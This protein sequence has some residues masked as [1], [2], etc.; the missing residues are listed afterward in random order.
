MLDRPEDAVEADLRRLAAREIVRRGDLGLRSY[1]FSHSLIRDLAYDLLV[2]SECVRRHGRI[3]DVLEAQQSTDYA[4]VGFHHDRAGHPEPAARAKLR[5][6]RICRTTG[7]Y[8]EGAALTARAIELIGDDLPDV[9]LRLEANELN[10]LFAT[11]TQP[12]A[13]VAGVRSPPVEL[14]AALPA[15]QPRPLDLHRQ[16]QPV[17]CGEHD[18]RP[19]TERGL[20][21]DVYRI[22]LRSFPGIVPFNQCARG[23]QAT[24]RGR[25]AHAEVLLRHSAERMLEIGVDPWMANHW[26]APDDPVALGLAYLPSVLLQRG[27]R[28]SGVEWLRRAWQRARDAG[29]R[30]V[31]HGAHL[32][33]LSPV[34][35]DAG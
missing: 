25:F 7:A 8:R 5:A 35:G 28:P 11:V 13:Y 4:L 2:P 10:H 23:F 32:R 17:G 19:S 34:L 14:R 15:D 33:E 24:L 9:S 31:Q 12:G 16:D 20:L 29:E 3:A 18:R 1:Q 22:G 21:Y 30:G 26:P 27:Y 6:A